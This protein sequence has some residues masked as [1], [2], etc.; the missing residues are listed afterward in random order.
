MKGLLTIPFSVLS[1]LSKQTVALYN[2]PQYYNTKSSTGVQQRWRER[3][4]ERGRL[5][6]GGKGDTGD[7]NRI[8]REAILSAPGRTVNLIIGCK[9]LK[10]VAKISYHR[11]ASANERAKINLQFTP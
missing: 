11:S 6:I 9:L 8:I 1:A 10:W 2:M 5:V 4:I 3:E 7:F